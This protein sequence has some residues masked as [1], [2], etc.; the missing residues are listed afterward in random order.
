M[1]DDLF[2]QRRDH[3]I[4]RNPTP[5]QSAMEPLCPTLVKPIYCARLG[6]YPP[7]QT[8]HPVHLRPSVLSVLSVLSIS[9]HPSCPSHPVRPVRPVHLRLS[10]LSISGCPSCLSCP[11][12]ASGHQACQSHLKWLF[13]HEWGWGPIFFFKDRQWMA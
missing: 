5:M 3:L 12:Q 2:L 13:D 4:A 1:F 7:G 8:V 11:S 10:V 9:G 6:G